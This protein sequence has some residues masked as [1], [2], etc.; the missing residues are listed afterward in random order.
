MQ[1]IQPRS[2]YERI[3]SGGPLDLIDVRSVTEFNDTHVPGSRSVPLHSIRPATLIA[4]RATTSA[5]LYVICQSGGRGRKA[6]ESI[7]DAGCNDVWNVDGGISA[8]IAAGLPV[9]RGRKSI[10]LEGQVRIVNGAIVLASALLSLLH[11][12][13]LAIVVFMG[14]GLIFSGVTGFCGLAI[15]MARAPWNGGDTL[16]ASGAKAR[17]AS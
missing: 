9:E 14:C 2:L 15:I 13:F 3:H 16:A 10:P 6:C 1:T 7:R 17:P 5:P 12:Y 11:P 8:W 4:N